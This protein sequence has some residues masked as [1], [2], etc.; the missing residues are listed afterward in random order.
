[1][2]TATDKPATT[3]LRSTDLRGA[4]RLAVAATLGLTD[5][6]EHLHH[7]ITQAPW[8]LG[9]P[10]DGPTRGV[11][12]LVYR[13]IR[14]VTRLVGGS[15]DALLSQAEWLLGPDSGVA[16]PERE[17]VVS[18]LNGVMGDRLA[19]AG[20]PLAIT[21]GLHL[22]GQ[23]L[24]LAPSA[25]AQR[26][27]ALRSKVLVMV[28][29]LCMGP[30][31]WR[32][33]GHD[34]GRALAEAGGFTPLYLHYNT[35]RHVADNG[36]ALA[37]LLQALHGSWPVPIDELVILAHSMGGLVARS[38]CHQ[39]NVRGDS[40]PKALRRMVFLGT[41]HHG[42]PLARGGQWIDTAL[43]AS[44]YTAAFA[45]LATKRSAGIGD[46][47]HGSLLVADPGNDPAVGSKPHGRDTHQPVQLPNGVACHAIAAS[48]GQQA[49]DLKDALLG[50][51]LVPVDSALG[52]HPQ[53]R[54]RLAFDADKQWIA[55]GLGHLD[56]LSSVEVYGQLK[57]WVLP[58]AA[59]AA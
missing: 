13:S 2:T 38:A 54:R 43:G 24:A 27:P 4:S 40:W 19:A 42:A 10:I 59:P 41:P 30:S 1:M 22:D 56:L 5:L 58:A 8:P 9:T 33:N 35:G 21:M 11:T 23:P 47:R 52:R 51:G 39:A 45:R 25:L 31:Q 18:A 36:L 15:L 3:H 26:G 48:L 55:Q 49:G 57:R 16:S 29:G 46:L 50:D 14:G 20:N 12:G 6:V 28:H 44:P 53:A 37:D 17:A 7:N 32:R 34:H